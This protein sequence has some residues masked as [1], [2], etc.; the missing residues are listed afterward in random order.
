LPRRNSPRLPDRLRDKIRVKHYSIRTEHAYV[1]WARRF[2]VGVGVDAEP[3]QECASFPV[4][5]GLGQRAALAPERGERQAAAARLPVVLGRDEVASVLN[6]TSGSNGL[7][8][9]GV[10]SPLDRMEQP[11]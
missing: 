11:R 8:A 5:G 1:D 4:Q 2:I 3:S 9:R 6:R 7:I 10:K